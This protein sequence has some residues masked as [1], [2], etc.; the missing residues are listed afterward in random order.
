[1]PLADY[2]E[3]QRLNVNSTGDVIHTSP[4][5]TNTRVKVFIMDDATGEKWYLRVDTIKHDV[6]LVC[7]SAQIT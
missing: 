5:G 1:M 3:S 7:Q 6:G 2:R 4:A